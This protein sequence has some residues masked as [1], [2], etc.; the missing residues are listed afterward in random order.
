MA[1]YKFYCYCCYSHWIGPAE[2]W[3]T[4][5]ALLTSSCNNLKNLKN[6]TVKAL[7]SHQFR[8]KISDINSLGLLYIGF[9][10]FCFLNF[11]VS[12][13][14]NSLRDVLVVFRAVRQTLTG[15]ECLYADGGMLDQYPIYW[16]DGMLHLSCVVNWLVDC[17]EM[18]GYSVQFCTAY[19]ITLDR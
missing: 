2:I 15:R 11:W 5:A 7:I 3:H 12:L 18:G 13:K 8:F 17:I 4:T 1:L 6:N 14:N 10:N 16:F 19:Q 9:L